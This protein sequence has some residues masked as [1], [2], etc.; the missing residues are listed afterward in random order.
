M[1]LLPPLLQ[2]LVLP[3]PVEAPLLQD[4]LLQPPVQAPL[5]QLVLL[6]LLHGGLRHLLAA[7][8]RLIPLLAA[9]NG[10]IH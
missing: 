7:P 10:H 8:S 4:W 3:P 2:P 6:P 9:R 1:V 5:L